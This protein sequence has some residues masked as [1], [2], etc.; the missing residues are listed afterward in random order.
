MPIVRVA[1]P[2]NLFLDGLLQLATTPAGETP[3]ADVAGTSAPWA[4]WVGRESVGLSAD[5]LA[6]ADRR[7]AIP[8]GDDV[9]SYSVN[10]AAAIALHGLLRGS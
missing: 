7:V 1:D 6:R 4:L 2:Q 10:A 5:L 3:L 8:M 9:D